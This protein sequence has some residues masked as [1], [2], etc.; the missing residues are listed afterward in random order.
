MS[1]A[2]LAGRF[3]IDYRSDAV[4]LERFAA[5][6]PEP[7]TY[8]MLLGGLLALGGASRRRRLRAA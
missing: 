1:V 5:A 6:V 4:V 8:A 7:Q 3:V 2:G